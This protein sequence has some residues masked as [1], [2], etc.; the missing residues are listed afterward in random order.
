MTP[1]PK[2]ID[3]DQRSQQHRLILAAVS[4]GMCPTCKHR[5]DPDAQAWGGPDLPGSMAG[6]ACHD[7]GYRYSVTDAEWQMAV[8]RDPWADRAFAAKYARATQFEGGDV[9]GA[10][11]IADAG[12]GASGTLVWVKSLPP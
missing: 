3:R 5:L 1:D 12:P 2:R 7:C 10:S 6:G 11:W 8:L 4:E 9:D